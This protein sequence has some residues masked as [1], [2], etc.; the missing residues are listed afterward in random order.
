MLFINV[1]EPRCPG[2]SAARRAVRSQAARSG[3]A[4]I[5]R[6]RMCEYQG[7]TMPQ[8]PDGTF[9]HPSMYGEVPE[10]G[11]LINTVLPSRGDDFDAC[12]R[13]LSSLEHRLFDHYIRI[14]VPFETRHC[15]QFTDPESYKH[16]I[17]TQ[18][19]PTAIADMG[20]LSGIFLYACRSLHILTK[21]RYYYE[22]ALYYKLECL[23]LLQEA[24]SSPAMT[25]TTM[26]VIIPRA[27][28][29][30]S[31]E[32]ALGDVP[33]CKSHMDGVVRM[34]VLKGGMDKVDAMHG[35]LR[36]MVSVFACSEQLQAADRLIREM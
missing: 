23:R 20:M 11:G 22:L 31:D 28:Q 30:A 33:T 32:L 10:Y 35:F 15:Q 25:A 7:R 2:T 36:Q 14:V 17:A 6:Q 16:N 3:H 5:R 4:K 19:V 9:N 27:L 26:D 29:L 1:D 13:A 24:L 21:D 18:W 34:V 12:C 8:L